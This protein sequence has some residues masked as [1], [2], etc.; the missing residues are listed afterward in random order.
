MLRAVL[1]ANVFLS[2]AINPSSAPG[3][4]LERFLARGSFELVVTPGIITEVRRAIGY[5]RVRKR[6]VPGLDPDEWLLD[7]V[8]FW[9]TSLPI[10]KQ[11]SVPREIPM[12]TG[13]WRPP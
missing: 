7:V 13:T 5:P 3:L 9:P 6:I 8:T 2:A 12:M 4:I 1:D 11:L 10:R